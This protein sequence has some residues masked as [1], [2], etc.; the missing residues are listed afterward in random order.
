[1]LQPPRGRDGLYH[2]SLK[3][4]LAPAPN[5]PHPC[6]CIQISV[7][8]GGSQLNS[9]FSFSLSPL[10]RHNNHLPPPSIRQQCHGAGQGGG[11]G[12]PGRTWTLEN[13]REVTRLV[14]LGIIMNE[15]R[16][17]APGTSA[18]V[19]WGFTYEIEIAGYIW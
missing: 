18:I 2:I 13:K 15:P 14:A 12:R 6:V 11:R 16:L 10:R 8:G 5:H 19:P 17:Q 1:M 3:A 4:S 9:G 7:I